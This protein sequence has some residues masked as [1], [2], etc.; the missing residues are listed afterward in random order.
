M[1]SARVL[2]ARRLRR[3]SVGRVGCIMFV[4]IDTHRWPPSGNAR[5][6][7]RR[8]FTLVELL[9]VVAV[10]GILLALLLPAVQAARESARRAGCKSNLRQIGVGLLNFHDTSGA[11]PVG[12]VDRMQR[13]IAW[14]AYLLPFIEEQDV[15][16]L[17]DTTRPY[18][19]PR[20]RAA[21]RALL[22]IYLC[23]STA[24]LAPGRIGATAGD[25]NANGID[26]PGDHL[27]MTDYGGMFGAERV[28]PQANGVLIFDQAI[29]IRHI[30]DG[31][32]HTIIVA[33]D[34]GRG[35]VW[36]GEWINGENIFDR[37]IGINRLQHNELWSD[38]ADGCFVLF[39]DSSVHF[40]SDQTDGDVLDALCTRSGGEVIR[41]RPF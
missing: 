12:C 14:S 11:F 21:G 6:N 15:Y 22:P 19:S 16:D 37:S 41:E 3:H 17:L 33:E 39:C 28:N 30:R 13:R 34:T 20:N 24:T 29:A 40:L 9:V 31:T 5:L 35:W 8:G 23:P 4:P 7:S 32:S 38:H 1:S 27:A 10:L 18:N 26:D 25:R 2:L 36:D